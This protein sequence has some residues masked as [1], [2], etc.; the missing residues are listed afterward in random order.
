MI[1]HHRFVFLGTGTADNEDRCQS[2]Y[3]LAAPGGRFLLF[4]TGSG[5]ETL[6]QIRRAGLEPTLLQSVFLTHRHLDHAAGLLPLLLW[7]RLRHGD[8][9]ARITVHGSAE[10][11][12]SLQEMHRLSGHR[13]CFS[14]SNVAPGERVSSLEGCTVEAVAVEHI[15]GSF[16]YRV[17]LPGSVLVLSGDTA[18]AEAVAAA[19]HHADLLIHEASF[20]NA[21]ERKAADLR[22]TTAEQA[23]ALARRAGAKRL[24]LTHLVS[25]RLIPGS[26]LR[27]EAE[28]GFGG[29]VELAGDL[30][31]LELD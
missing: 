28:A 31:S 27:S 14:F 12:Q 25:D 7:M 19:A 5:L 6:K 13:G 23:G 2:S 30:Q 17:S 16:G 9:A 22:H 15:T 4:D 29:T 1:S 26:T 24:V 21:Q 18:P 10:T 11:V 3:A 8:L 20:D